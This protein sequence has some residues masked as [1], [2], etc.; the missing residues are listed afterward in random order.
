MLDIH[1]HDGAARFATLK[2]ASGKTVALPGT[3]HTRDVIGA[4][5][6]IADA[7][8]AHA[9]VWIF[10]RGSIF[11]PRDG[12]ADADLVIQCDVPY[13][14]ASGDELDAAGDAENV[15]R[16]GAGEAFVAV[17][18]DGDVP[19]SASVVVMGS[20][21]TLV[22][23]P[24]R[25]ATHVTRVRDRSGFHRALYAP[26]CALPE[27][28]SLLL[29]VGVDLVDDVATRLAAVRGKYLT[30]EGAVPRESLI[31]LP[32]ACDACRAAVATP[33]E[34]DLEVHN[35]HALS[36]ELARCRVA[37]R[38]GRLRELVE[39]RVRAR[40]HLAASLRR[41]DNECYEFTEARAP[42]LRTGQL[43]ATSKESLARVEVERF[44][45]RIVHRYAKPAS[46]RVALIL[47]CSA[48]KPYSESR[49]HR[50]LDYTLTGIGNRA[51]VHELIMTSPLG[52]VPRELERVYPAAHYDLAVTG[53]WD[54]DETQMIRT[55]IEAYA[56]KNA[57]DH[58]IIHLDPV[59]AAIVSPALEAAGI[60]FEVT[61]GDDPLAGKNLETL[62]MR[63][64]AAAG[65]SEKVGWR[66]RNL[67][68][69]RALAS[70][71]F[72]ADAARALTRDADARGRPPLI[73]IFSA[74]HKQLAMLVPDRGLLALTLD[75]GARVFEAGTGRVEIENFR[76]KGTVFAVGVIGADDDVRPEDE[77]VLH[78][79][80]VLKA[81]GRA[82]MNG[83]EMTEA[84]H[85]GAVAV[86]HYE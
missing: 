63:V 65:G 5:A 23:N 36:L 51:S 70:W 83:R 86:R 77:V 76:P 13:S 29:Y 3:L 60:T 27:N 18:T 84:K 64:S 41:L 20:A 67:D 45:R 61:G 81:V 62:R 16:H 1:A 69:M 46:T 82:L 19:A 43:F 21:A 6:V 56:R 35:A 7:R 10:D 24:Y 9:P 22:E 44:R 37:M 32:C 15:A 54:A 68:D 40:P 58:V 31:D 47:P 17:A 12:P 38:E 2:L 75:G 4:A 48:R 52:L 53:D 57:Y 33:T 71:Q 25:F 85:G 8:P 73:K 79:K 50:R 80:G 49:T 26:A 66:E 55:L 14:P 78:H 72:G 28:L 59:E 39:M 34:V 30:P 11:R 74:D 42:V